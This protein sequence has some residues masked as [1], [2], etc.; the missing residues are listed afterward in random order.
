MLHIKQ[1]LIDDEEMDIIR[2]LFKAYQLELDENLCFQSFEKELQDPLAVYPPG[3]GLLLLAYWNE[4]PAGCIAL[5]P[6]NEEGVCEMKRLFVLPEFRKF[7]IGR[8]LTQ[9]LLEEAHNLGYRKMKLDTLQK[10][11]PAIQLYESLGFKHTDAYYKNPLQDVV[12]MEKDLEEDYRQ[13]NF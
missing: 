1:I 2:S 13:P 4:K 3:K 11:K 8:I 6:L 10:L 12:Y 9:K 7:G 5:K